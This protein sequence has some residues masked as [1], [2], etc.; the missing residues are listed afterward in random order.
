MQQIRDLAYGTSPLNPLCYPCGRVR[1]REGLEKIYPQNL[2]NKENK[3]GK[4]KEI[5]GTKHTIYTH[6]DKLYIIQ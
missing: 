3:K 6:W 1:S 2:K 5:K 4:D